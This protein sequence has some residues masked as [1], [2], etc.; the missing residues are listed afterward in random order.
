MRRLT[1]SGKL[2]Q[3]AEPLADKGPAQLGAY[4]A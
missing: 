4:T 3:P 1:A 2:P